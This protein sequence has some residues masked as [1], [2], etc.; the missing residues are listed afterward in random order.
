M[1]ADKLDYTVTEPKTPVERNPSCHE[2]SHQSTLESNTP[3]HGG[4]FES[5]TAENFYG[6]AVGEAYRIK[7]ELVAEHLNNIGFGK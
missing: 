4:R 6:N 1:S 2:G 3:H 7:S 5:A